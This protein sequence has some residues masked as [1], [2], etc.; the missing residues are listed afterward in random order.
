[1][2]PEPI[3]IHSEYDYLKSGILNGFISRDQRNARRYGTAFSELADV[4]EFLC[5][6]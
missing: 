6:L 3:T 5:D 4:C 1:L 2:V